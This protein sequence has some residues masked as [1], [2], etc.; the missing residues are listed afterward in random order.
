MLV[1]RGLN[2]N[3]TNNEGETPLILVAK[4]GVKDNIRLIQKLLELKCDASMENFKNQSFYSIVTNEAVKAHFECN[5]V[6]YVNHI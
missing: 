3:E 5:S 2:I 1:E 4:S 6:S